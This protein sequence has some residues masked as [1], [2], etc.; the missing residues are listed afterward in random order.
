M[1]LFALKNVYVLCLFLGTSERLWLWFGE[2]TFGRPQENSIPWFGTENMNMEALHGEG[3]IRS[4]RSSTS[5]PCMEDPPCS[6]HWHPPPAS[7]AATSGRNNSSFCKADIMKAKDRGKKGDKMAVVCQNPYIWHLQIADR[8]RQR[9]QWLRKTPLSLSSCFTCTDF[10]K[11]SLLP[12]SAA[13]G[14]VWSLEIVQILCF[15]PRRG[16]SGSGRC[17]RVGMRFP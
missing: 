12:H 1:S 15:W 14:W 4:G 13:A 11:L 5:D 2:G 17:H 6:S 9:Q 16:C 10:K 7:P 3:R 8:G